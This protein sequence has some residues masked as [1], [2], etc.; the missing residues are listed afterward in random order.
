MKRSILLIAALFVFGYCFPQRVAQVSLSGNGSAP[1]ISFLVDGTLIIN[2]SK[3]GRIVEFGQEYNKQSMNYYPGRLQPYLGRTDNYPADA[4]EGYKGKLRD[5]GSVVI[6]YYTAEENEF[7]KGK[8]KAIG[9]LPIE[10]YPK[11]DNDAFKGNIKNAG[12]ISF[13]WFSSFDNDGYKG[14]LKT[15][16][17]T[18]ITFYSSFDDIAYRGKLK[19]IGNYNYTYYSSFDRKEYYGLMKSGSQVQAINGISFINRY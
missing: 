15:I 19:S 14:K 18:S 7:L 3:D 2:L 11:Y 6:T 9:T 13:E 16:G 8:V 17:G 4:N 10:Y 1:V 12:A 5:A